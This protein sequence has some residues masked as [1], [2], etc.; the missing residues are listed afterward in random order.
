ME[1]LGTPTVTRG[2]VELC[3]ETIPTLDLQF[4]SSVKVYLVFGEDGVGLAGEPGSAASARPSLLGGLIEVNSDGGERR[5]LMDYR[6]AVHDRPDAP[7]L[8]ELLNAGEYPGDGRATQ[9]ALGDRPAVGG[10]EPTKTEPVAEATC[11]CLATFIAGWLGG[12]QIAGGLAAQAADDAWTNGTAEVAVNAPGNLECVLLAVDT[13]LPDAKADLVRLQSADL[14]IVPTYV[15]GDAPAAPVA[16]PGADDR[17]DLGL[18]A[19]V[20]GLDELPG[21]VSRAPS[22]TDQLFEQLASVDGWRGPD[23]WRPAPAGT[24]PAGI[25][26]GDA[27]QAARAHPTATPTDAGRALRE[28]LDGYLK[29]G[30]KGAAVVAALTLEGLLAYVYWR[31]WRSGRQVAPPE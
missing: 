16:P 31:N 15:V 27:P 3:G 29:R 10:N 26:V 9:P 28:W 20:V 5:F 6:G 18:T 12:K 19:R 14:T 25:E 23:G 8:S 24:Q 17:P 2:T 1:Q 22:P 30:G 7:P 13:V 11:Q 21:G 4:G